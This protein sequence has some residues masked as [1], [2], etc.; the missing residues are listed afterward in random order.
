MKNFKK[1]AIIG[2]GLIGGSLALVIRK[3][4]SHAEIIGVTRSKKTLR[5]AKKMGA[6][7]K[8]F[9]DVSGIGDAELVV[10]AA[11][12]ET[13]IRLAQEAAGI[14]SPRCLV[15]DVGSTKAAITEKLQGLFPL[16]VG[17]HPLAGLE[18]QGVLNANAGIFK[19]ASCVL[20]PTRHTDK[21]ALEGIKSFWKAIGCRVVLLSPETHDKMFSFLSHLPHA[22]AFSLINTVPDE[23]LGLAASGLK[24]TTRIAASDSILWSD[25][26]LSNKHILKAIDLFQKD[27]AGLREAI[28][29]GD[30]KRLSRILMAASKKRQGL[31]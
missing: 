30:R 24:D 3:R 17:S 25:I 10:F 18:K 23:Y 29:K 4:Y 1:I 31:N 14:I 16:Y 11:P 5:L 20:T 2:V 9:Q 6:I 8:G 15:T 12:V 7:D 27:L 26:F 22:V 21:S 28:K 19:G 13:I